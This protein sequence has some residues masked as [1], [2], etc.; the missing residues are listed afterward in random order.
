MVIFLSMFWFEGSFDGF[1]IDL[2]FLF[3]KIGIIELKCLEGKKNYIL[4]EV[5]EDELFYIELV[6]GKFNLKKDYYLGYYI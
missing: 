6:D 5:M 4:Q 1:V 3:G 2:C